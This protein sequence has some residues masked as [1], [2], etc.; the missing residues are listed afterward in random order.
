MQNVE[1]KFAENQN[2]YTLSGKTVHL[3]ITEDIGLN[4]LLLSG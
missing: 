1:L 2:L 4:Y 3:K